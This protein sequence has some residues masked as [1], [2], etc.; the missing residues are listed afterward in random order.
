MTPD[1]TKNTW[2]SSITHIRAVNVAFGEEQLMPTLH[3]TG[4]HRDNFT[5]L[6]CNAETSTTL[7][8]SKTR[9]GKRLKPG[10]HQKQRRTQPTTHIYYKRSENNL[11]NNNRHIRLDLKTT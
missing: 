2:Q 10:T 9:A 11:I 8:H 1:F 5:S 3:G 7:E 4:T 6:E